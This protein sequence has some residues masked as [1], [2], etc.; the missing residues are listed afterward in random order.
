MALLRPA[1]QAPLLA[2]LALPGLALPAHPRSVVRLAQ[3]LAAFLHRPLQP[4]LACAFRWQKGEGLLQH[5]RCSSAQLQSHA[6]GARG[7]AVLASVLPS[8]HCPAPELARQSLALLALHCSEAWRHW[9]AQPLVHH[10]PQAPGL[11]RCLGLLGPHRWRLVL[12]LFALVARL[13][14]WLEWAKAHGL[15]LWLRVLMQA[16]RL[17]LA[18]WR[19]PHRTVQ[20]LLPVVQ[21]GLL[22]L[23]WP[24]VFRCCWPSHWQ[25]R[26]Q[27]RCASRPGR[28][29]CALLAAEQKAPA[30]VIAL[31]LV[32]LRGLARPAR[33][34]T[35]AVGR[36]ASP[37]RLPRR[38]VGLWIQR[39]RRQG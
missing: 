14:G 1:L 19:P 12:A 16:Q 30:E 38:R 10:F 17:P 35:V 7:G 6:Q 31:W 3:G 13:L 15:L 33:R 22:V 21:F 32:L 28:A 2:C 34:R 18:A 29:L 11:P 25:C 9:S 24:W 5:H 37:Q 20:G 23:A 4:A 27:Q 36:L 8:S 39:G 26:A